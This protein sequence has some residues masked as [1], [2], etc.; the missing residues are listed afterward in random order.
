MHDF[1]SFLFSKH[2][3][4]VKYLQ[5]TF[6]N[7]P[8]LMLKPAETSTVRMFSGVAPQSFKESRKIFSHVYRNNYAE[9]K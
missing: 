7:A 4:P 3:H 9:L 6:K 2:E 8:S 1:F 5:R